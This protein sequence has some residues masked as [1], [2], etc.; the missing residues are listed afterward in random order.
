MCRPPR[1]TTRSAAVAPAAVFGLS[2]DTLKALA[3]GGD[4][5]ALYQKGDLRV[6][7]DVL[8]ARELTCLAGLV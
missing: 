5:V 6:D 2:D 3:D 8:L 4:L 7:G 1:P